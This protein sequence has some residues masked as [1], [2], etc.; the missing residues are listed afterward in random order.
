MRSLRRSRPVSLAMLLTLALGGLTGL[1]ADVLT[2]VAN[3]LAAVR[4]WRTKVAD[5]GGELAQQGLVRR[6]QHQ[7]R[8]LRVRRHDRRDGRRHRDVGGMGETERER[9][10]LALHLGAVTRA[11]QLEHL[12]VA[13]GRALHGAL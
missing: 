9:D 11:D 10:D 1:A 3:A 2:A 4:L 5:T 7:L 8:A 12:L 13:L 6:G